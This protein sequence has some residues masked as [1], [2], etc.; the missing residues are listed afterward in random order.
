MRLFSPGETFPPA[1]FGISGATGAATNADA[2]PTLAVY[3]NGVLDSGVGVTV[4]N[5]AT[6]EYSFT[7]GIPIG[8]ALGD[9]VSVRATATVAGIVLAPQEIV[10]FRLDS[11]VSTRSVAGD[12]MALTGGER[13][14][15]YAGIWAAGTR[16]LT[17]ISDSA[18][19]TTLLSRL[20]STRAAYLDALTALTE[21]RMVWLERLGTALEETSTGSGIWRLTTLALSRLGFDVSAIR[22]KTD[23]LPADPA[24]NAQVNTRL[25]TSGY[26]APDNA[27][28]STAAA[29]AATAATQATNAAT[30]AASADSKLTTGR[31][32]NLDAATPTRLGILDRLAGM[33]EQVTGLWRWTAN[34]QSQSPITPAAPTAEQLAAEVIAQ[35]IFSQTAGL[36][37]LN[38]VCRDFTYDESDNLTSFRIRVYDSPI[39][40]QSDDPEVGL[41]SSFIVNNVLN[42]QG[43]VTKTITKAE[44]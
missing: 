17:A 24:S 27:G 37:G 11:K 41:L 21:G 42:G 3:R 7:F 29:S 44:T 14:T 43:Q 9:V 10:S 30:S 39:H 12:A 2:T 8:Y 15:L 38:Q 6:G 5:P 20:T 19:V 25:A 35:A 31:L 13:T 22:V 16:T 28:I 32:T 23:A 1:R 36:T 18:G 33:M 34:T 4:L 40:A 26:T